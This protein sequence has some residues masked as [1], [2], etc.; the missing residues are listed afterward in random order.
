MRSLLC[1]FPVAVLA[2]TC[3][4]AHAPHAGEKAGGKQGSK[5]KQS[6]VVRFKDNPIIRPAMLP[7]EDGRNINGPS[8]IRVPDWVEKPLGKYYLYFAHHRGT[9]IRLAYADRLEGPWSIHK[10]GTLKLEDVEAAA[11]YTRVKG[12]HIASLDVHVDQGKKA[13]R[14]YFHGKVGPAARWGHS[15]GVA[16]SRDGIHFKPLPQRLGEPYFRVFRW[17][18]D[19]YAVTRSG[20]LVRSKDGLGPF[21][22]ANTGFDEATRDRQSKAS[23]RHTARRLDGKILSVFFSRVGDTPERILVSRAELTGPHTSWRLSAPQEVLRPETDYEGGK[24]PLKPSRGGLVN[25]PVRQLRDPAIF[26]EGGR[27]YLLY[28]VAGEHGIAIAELKE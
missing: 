10:P 18:D 12:G 20:S 3:L 13:I 19:Y 26:R 11:G 7:G 22:E 9:Y 2:L 14:M 15:S 21:G 23:I 17:G 4:T 5:R 27:T 24:L 25:V 6:D 1:A 16:L 28:A 8:L